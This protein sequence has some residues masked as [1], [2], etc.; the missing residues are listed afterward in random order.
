V[1]PVCA[2]QEVLFHGTI[3]GEQSAEATAAGLTGIMRFP[4]IQ[5]LACDAGTLKKGSPF[6]KK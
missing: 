4:E 3:K 6:A 1:P 2:G 5:G